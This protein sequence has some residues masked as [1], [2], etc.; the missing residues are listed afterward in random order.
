MDSQLCG[1]P[2][3]GVPLK[4][5]EYEYIRVPQNFEEGDYFAVY[6]R[7]KDGRYYRFIG[8]R[9]VDGDEKIALTT[10]L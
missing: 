10:E 2:L 9:K 4:N 5:I 6:Q 1:G 8:W 3:D 7:A